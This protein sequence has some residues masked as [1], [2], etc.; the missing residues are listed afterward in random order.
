MKYFTMR[1]GEK[2]PMQITK[3]KAEWFLGGCYKKEAV[4]DIFE[5]DRE[6]RLRTPYRVIWTETEDGLVPVPGFEGIVG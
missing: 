6:F 2:E 5:N 4:R 3:D 1:H